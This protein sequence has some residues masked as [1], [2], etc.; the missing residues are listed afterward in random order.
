[1]CSKFISLWRVR[2]CGKLGHLVEEEVVRRRRVEVV[3]NFESGEGQIG[4]RG[5]LK[6]G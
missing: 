6:R 2:V 4:G 5:G 1:V 3:V